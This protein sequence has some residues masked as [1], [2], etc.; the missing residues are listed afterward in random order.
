MGPFYHWKPRTGRAVWPRDPEGGGGGAAFRLQWTAM[1]WIAVV[2]VLLG[3][4][5]RAENLASA[6][7]GTLAGVDFTDPA[8]KKQRV[9]TG[10]LTLIYE[11]DTFANGSDDNFTA[12]FAA[13]WTSAPVRTLSPRNFFRRIPE[14]VFS[15]LPTLKDPRYT[16]F[17]QIAA[18]LGMYTPRDIED[19]DP[20][21]GSHPYAGILSLDLLI[22]TTNGTSLNGFVLR[23]GV[24]GPATG[25]GRFQNWGHRNSDRAEAQGWDQQLSNEPIL[26][27]FY[28][29]Q[30]RLG[31]WT[32]SDRGFGFDA[33]VN[34]GAGLGNYYI[35]ANLGLQVRA[36]FALPA[37]FARSNPLNFTEEIVGY[38]PQPERFMGY[39]F[40]QVIGTGVARF[41]PID[42]NTFSSSRSGDRDNFFSNLIVGAMIGSGRFVLLFQV[43]LFSDGLRGSGSDEDYATVTASWIF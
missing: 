25:A 32:H 17:T 34:G 21:Q 28:L 41:L 22:F 9:Y 40:A 42:G 8:L 24:V 35:G 36:G 6:I 31:R 14:E 39:L 2:L 20:P 27:L 37:N 1:R 12:G 13:S 26:N 7:E 29:H 30:R 19:D 33:S 43:N 10:T 38:A 15:F 4:T 18:S 16:K 5:A 11:N 23:L 3:P